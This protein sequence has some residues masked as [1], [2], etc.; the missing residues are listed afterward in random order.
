MLSGTIRNAMQNVKRAVALREH[1]NWGKNW[2]EDVELNGY[3]EAIDR[4]ASREK[5][6]PEIQ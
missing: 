5:L 3:S 6:I 2:L 1:E 4:H